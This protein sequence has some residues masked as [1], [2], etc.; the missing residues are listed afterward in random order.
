MGLLG[1]SG[2]MT[3]SFLAFIIFSL[4]IVYTFYVK[5]SFVISQLVALTLVFLAFIALSPLIPFF[6]FDLNGTTVLR[7]SIEVGVV[8]FIFIGTYNFVRTKVISPKFLLYTI[9]ILGLITA[10]YTLSSLIGRAS[11]HRLRSVTGVNYLGNIFAICAIIWLMILN[12]NTL[13]VGN[14]F[15]KRTIIKFF[16]F[17]FVFLTMMLTGTRSAAIAF[18]SGILALQFFGIKS[19]NFNRY[20]FFVL[21]LIS[22]LLLILSTQV[23][24]SSLFYRYT[25]EELSRMAYIRFSIYAESVTDLTLV[26]LFT[27][28]PD[29]YIFTSGQ[30]GD[31]MVNTHNLFLS[32][33][34]YH[35]VTAL[36]LFVILLAA[37]TLNYLK[38][39]KK[40][41]KITAFRFT[42]SST[43]IILVIALVYSMFS[44]GRP[45][46]TFIL[47][48][49]LGYMAGYL[50]LLKNVNS[51]K[52]YKKMIL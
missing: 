52:E 22:A 36:I 46:R 20:A 31:R 40:N 45:T 4:S 12:R 18:F 44:G 50:E 6:F 47:F 13:G 1:L 28:R 30:D 29:L 19:K 14:N 49:S 43:I 2:G 48:I 34:R 38:L 42:E 32:L 37:V 35:G 10:L 17:F 11:V 24:F 33:I 16:C 7:L 3:A 5:E 26:E 9:A 15:K 39:Y 41:K 27:G 51:I 8:I 23:D 21:V 25:L